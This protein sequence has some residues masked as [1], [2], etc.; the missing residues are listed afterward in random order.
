MF[1]VARET[2][3]NSPQIEWPSTTS[4]NAWVNTLLW[5]R[6]NTPQDAVFAVD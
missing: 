6:E 1:F 4:T 2:Y 5:V 3:P